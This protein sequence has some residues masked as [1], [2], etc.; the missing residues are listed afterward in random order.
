[1]ATPKMKAGPGRPR[2]VSL[3]AQ[4]FAPLAE[5]AALASMPAQHIEAARLALVERLPTAAIADRLDLTARAVSRAVAAVV[6]M[7]SGD[8][9]RQRSRSRQSMTA[10][11]FDRLLPLLEAKGTVPHRIT[12]ARLTLVDRLPD[13][14]V[15][16]RLGL[17]TRQSVA[18]ARNLVWGLYQTMLERSAPPDL[19]PGWVML[20]IAAPA[21]MADKFRREVDAAR[22]GLEKKPDHEGRA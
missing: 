9:P 15:A 5:R 3:S 7:R 13:S 16:E 8:Q 2:A 12:A 6:K 14:A 1:M 11:E 17:K 19:P 10:A 18:A 21:K 22:C 4:E 20:T